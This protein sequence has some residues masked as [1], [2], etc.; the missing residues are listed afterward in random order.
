MTTTIAFAGCKDLSKAFFI[1]KIFGQKP[2]DNI[3]LQYYR[4]SRIYDFLMHPIEIW[5]VSIAAE[6]AMMKLKETHDIV[7]VCFDVN[8]N[9]KELKEI[10]TFLA[11]QPYAPHLVIFGIV[12]EGHAHT[13]GPIIPVKDM[14]ARD[15][16]KNLHA[17]NF[18]VK[19]TLAPVALDA[20]V[21]RDFWW[22]LACCFI[23]FAAEFAKQG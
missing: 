19:V 7:V 8:T 9:L 2:H 5:D 14:I 18:F 12:V 11:Q 4:A 13:E 3:A 21:E 10:T 15:R 20:S 17:R 22:K 1:Y 16:I 23:A 6:I